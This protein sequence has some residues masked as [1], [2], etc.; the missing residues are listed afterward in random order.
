MKEKSIA[1]NIIVLLAIVGCMLAFVNFTSAG[2][3]SVQ[4]LFKLDPRLT[5]SL[6]M[7]DR[8]V[9]PD[10]FTQVG[11]GS[12]VIVEAKV[13]RDDGWGR[14]TTLNANCSA[15]NSS[16]ATVSTLKG[17]IAR[18]TVSKEGTTSLSLGGKTFRMEA[19][20]ANGSLQVNI[21]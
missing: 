12:V 1:K 16:M 2:Q 9:S 21:R 3:N 5:R 13:V 15:S 20:M 8:W 17:N 4:I 10:V 6:Y 7:G 18:I 14:S 11:E 19:K